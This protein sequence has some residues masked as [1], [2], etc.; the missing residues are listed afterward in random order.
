MSQPVRHPHHGID[1]IEISVT[2][3]EAAKRFYHDAFDWQFNE[4]G[5]AYAGIKKDGGGEAG[6]LCL[7]D[8]VNTGGPLV[9][10]Y[11]TDLHATLERVRA[12]SM[13]S[14]PLGSPRPDPHITT[15]GD[16]QGRLRLDDHPGTPM[17]GQIGPGPVH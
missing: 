11:S 14:N 3:I 12:V 13:D 1:Y 8:S 16:R 6:G 5:P 4:Y 2:D 7:A 15:A 9:V 17:I 10:L